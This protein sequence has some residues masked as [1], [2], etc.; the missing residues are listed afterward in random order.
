MDEIEEIKRKIDIVDL[1]SSYLTL[2]KAGA[3][4]RALCPFHNEKTPS[5]MIS[6]EKQIFKCFGCG[7]GGDIFSFVMKME[8]LEF[9]E[10]LEML[11]ARAG[12]KLEKYRK[13]ISPSEKPDKKTR[14]FRLNA[15]IAQIYHKILISHPSGKAALTY[16]KN[17]QISE[18][19]IKEFLIGYAPSSRAIK[20]YLSKKGFTDQE[21]QNAGGPDRFYRRIIFPITDVFGNVLGFTGRAMDKDQQPKYL[22]TPETI[23]F[24]KGR[25][26][27]NLNRARGEI[28]LQK[29]TVVVEGQMDVISSYQAGVK[30][31][32]ASSGTALT[33]DHLK[34]L[35]RYAPNI[36]FAFDSDTAGLATAKKAHEMALEESFNVKMTELGEFKDP[37][38]MI[39]KDAKLWQETIKNAKPVI[40]WYFDLAFNKAVDGSRKAETLTSQEKKEIAK[41]ILPIINKIPDTIEQADYIGKLAKKLELPEKIIFEALSNS[42]KY[43]VESI[44]YK[45]EEK[46][47]FKTINLTPDDILIGLII[48][49]P[50]I[51]KTALE[52]I[53][54]IDLSSKSQ[55]LYSF[56]EEWYNKDKDSDLINFLEKK[57]DT[58]EFKELELLLLEIEEKYSEN[59]DETLEDIINKILSDKKEIIKE[60]Y[61]LAIKKAESEGDHRK[62][63]E[64]IKE[65]QE[66]IK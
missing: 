7:E 35:Y 45:K 6:Q 53:K 50:H 58:T 40:D 3:N 65:F 61:A 57:L 56:I 25:I 34:I 33:S 8:N 12:V 5:L 20:A 21:I 38:E 1:V 22:N 59:I 44:K 9:R 30:N 52:K 2:K 19:T 11:A 16:L 18:Q 43:K 60:K 47:I 66:A 24:H 29:T 13:Q 27:Y 4:Y 49:N 41:E 14:L 55:K 64:L 54:S 63:K 17:R 10:A 15:L 48:K 23:I 31:V 26:L 42:R 36:I 51:V 28:K 32:V 39:E 62:L 46:N 37:G